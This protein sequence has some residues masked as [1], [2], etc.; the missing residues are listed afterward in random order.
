MEGVIKMRKTRYQK[1]RDARV[2]GLTG[3]FSYC[4]QKLSRDET[5]VAIASVIDPVVRDC[6]KTEARLERAG[7]L[8]RA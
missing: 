8:I 4:S 3:I 6:K 7:I 1:E 2:E 5:K